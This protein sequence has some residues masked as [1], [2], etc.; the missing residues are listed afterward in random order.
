MQVSLRSLELDGE[1]LVHLA[2]VGLD[3]VGCGSRS[4]PI[5]DS[6]VEPDFGGP[7]RVTCRSRTFQAGQVIGR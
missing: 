2:T 3:Q 1:L 4:K 7:N 6:V 5:D